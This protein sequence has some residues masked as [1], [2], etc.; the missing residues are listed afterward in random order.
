M[1]EN[2]KVSSKITLL[3][4]ALLIFMLVLGI[5]GFY[6][7]AKSNQSM[8]ILYNKNLKSIEYLSD[9]RTGARINEANVLYIILNSDNKNEQEYYINNL[10]ETAQINNKYYEN[11]IAIEDLDLYEKDTYNKMKTSQSEYRK[12][13]ENVI[14]LAKEGKQKE[15]YNLYAENM[16]NLEIYQN[17]VSDLVNYSVEKAN[18]LKTYNDNTY[19]KSR[20]LFAAIIILALG[21]GI[22]LSLL[23]TKAVM[24]PLKAIS[25]HLKI[26]ATG[27]FSQ[28]ITDKYL[29]PKDELGE[30]ARDTDAM[31]KSVIDIIKSV[32]SETEIVNTAIAVSNINIS[33][34][35]Q[36]LEKASVTVEQLSAGME[37]T[38]A[39]TQEI[40]AT[41][42]EIETAIEI[43]AKKA[44]DGAISANEISKK[45]NVLK[46]NANIS[47]ANTLE[48]RLSI[49]CAMNEALEKAKE[50]ERIKILSESILQISSQT[51]LLALNAAIEAARAGEAGKG[52]SVVAEEIRKL[53]ED[54]KS[55]VN[56]IQNTIQ[57]IFE[58]V[59][60]LEEASKRA[61]E[62][63]DTQVMEGYR[64][65]V[66]T[67]ENY[68][69]DAVLIEGLVTDLS[70][71]SEELLASIKTV[72]DAIDEISKASNEG[73]E[74]TNEI[75]DKV[76]KIRDRANEVKVETDHIMQS[77]DHLKDLISKF[78]I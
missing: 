9:A 4:A 48:V 59:N 32:I 8:Q 49:D 11:F 66:Q 29:Q 16:K 70:A 57:I 76:L 38:A 54:S 24:E 33:E 14:K 78:S 40:N 43:I 63:I 75:A 69:K 27:D 39:S 53:A 44:Q 58:A 56:E 72:S 37:E 77:S 20:V 12:I 31:Q 65:L 19:K 7:Y 5:S 46:N 47:Q 34:L 26:L 68:D 62:F 61:L 42:T 30:I 71:T 13:R 52:F 28:S 64:E 36:N 23:I 21:L 73:T 45:A 10:N 18:E 67:G 3:S 35:A 1:L 51:N 55:T 74:E 15:A 22:I 17:A 25:K 2:L 50:V 60:S 41:S 6:Y